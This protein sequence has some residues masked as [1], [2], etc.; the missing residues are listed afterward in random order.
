[1][2][3]VSLTKMTVPVQGGNST[4]GLLMPKLKYRFRIVFRNFGKTNSRE[5]LTKQVINFNRPTVDFQEIPLHVYNSTIKVAGK[6]TWSDTTISLRDDS[7]GNVSQLVG[8]QLQYQFDFMEQASA[9]AGVDYK[10]ETDCEILDGGNGTFEPT[11]LER[12]TL[13]GCYIKNANYQSLDYGQSE[14]A[15]IDLTLS[16]D[17]AIQSNGVGNNMGRNPG[18]DATG[19]VGR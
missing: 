11:V 12:W 6:H 14:A 3:A 16:F 17:N 4:Q 1:M 13:Y 10:F 8:E 5:E 2:A 18:I 9:A 15:T 19:T 7:V